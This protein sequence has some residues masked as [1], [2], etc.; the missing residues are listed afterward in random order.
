MGNRRH[1]LSCRLQP[2]RVGGKRAARAHH[3]AGPIVRRTPR[4]AGQAPVAEVPPVDPTRH[5]CDSPPILSKRT[6]A[7]S[8]RNLLAPPWL[9]ITLTA[10][11]LTLSL[12]AR[13]TMSREDAHLTIDHYTK[14]DDT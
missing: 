11:G 13:R 3:P 12:Y 14:A 10:C 7:T 4:L 6:R 9:R 5:F 8:I 1:H 2:S